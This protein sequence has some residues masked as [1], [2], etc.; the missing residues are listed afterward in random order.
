MKRVYLMIAFMLLIG[1][2]WQVVRAQDDQGIDP[3]A[4]IDRILSVDRKQR[5]EV[6]DVTFDAEYIEGDRNDNGELKQKVRFL[7]KIFV[8]YEDDTALFKEKYLTYYKNGELQSEDK[9]EKEAASRQEKRI[10]RKAKDISYDMLKPFYP[11]ERVHYTIAYKGV[12]NQQIEHYTCYHFRVEA[13]EEEEQYI[14]GDYYIDAESFHL[15]EVDFSPAKL[16]RKAMFKMNELRMTIMYGPTD[17]GYWFPRQFDIELSAKAMFL[18]GVSLSG[19]EYY[20]N[21]V[22]NSGLSDDL[23]KENSND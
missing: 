21:P 3:E 8:K 22:V 14:N 9:L 5:S 23:F 16:V 12:A 1:T 10:S 11:D 20:R 15:V 6:H 18:I 7:K 4:L 2:G 19:T 13:K 17:D